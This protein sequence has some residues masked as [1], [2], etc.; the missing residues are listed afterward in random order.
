MW[1]GMMILWLLV[2]GTTIQIVKTMDHIYAN[3]ALVTTPM[4]SDGGVYQLVI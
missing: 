4:M 2:V 1:P 3:T